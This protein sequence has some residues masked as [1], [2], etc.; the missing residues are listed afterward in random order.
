MSKPLPSL[1]NHNKVSFFAL[2]VSPDVFC[3]D[4][5]F[6]TCYGIHET[7][8][9]PDVPSNVSMY[10]L[11]KFGE[12]ELGARSRQCENFVPSKLSVKAS[13]PFYTSS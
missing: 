4:C 11:K 5:G 7:T 13:V 9:K 3:L 6:T 10:S 8:M 2:W 12:V 1:N